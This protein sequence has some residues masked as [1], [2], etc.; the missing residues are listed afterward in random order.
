MAATGGGRGR[1]S[2]RGRGQACVL[3]PAP[4]RAKQGI[5]TSADEE[6]YNL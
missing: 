6:R 4:G 1:I 5:L 2:S 3:K